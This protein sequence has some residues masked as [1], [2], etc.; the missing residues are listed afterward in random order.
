MA[1]NKKLRTHDP[2]LI[3]RKRGRPRGSKNKPKVVAP[4]DLLETLK[5]EIAEAIELQRSEFP[6]DDEATLR[7]RAELLRPSRYK[8]GR[9]PDF[10]VVAEEER[11]EAAA[12]AAADAAAKLPAGA[13]L[14]KAWDAIAD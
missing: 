14:A 8:E 9:W 3:K 12:R 1:A 6:N 4:P 10:A 11:K 2:E 13:S 5:A 7:Y